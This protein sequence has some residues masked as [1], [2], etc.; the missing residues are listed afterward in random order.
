MS[1]AVS[2]VRGIVRGGVVVLESSTQLPEGTEVEV[3][4]AAPTADDAPWE[5]L[6]DEAWSQID[7]G[8]GE[9][10]RDSG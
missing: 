7:W 6:A 10:A 8:E 9:I 5:S 2:T 4:P 3:K 1:M